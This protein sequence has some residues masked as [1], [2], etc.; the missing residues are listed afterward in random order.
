MTSSFNDDETCMAKLRV[1]K[2]F[3]ELYAEVPNLRRCSSEP[4][5]E[6]ASCSRL[7][8]IPRCVTSTHGETSGAVT[9]SPLND[10]NGTAPLDTGSVELTD[11]LRSGDKTVLFRNIP[12]KIGYER[13]MRELSHVGLDGR[14]D[15]LYLP[16]SVRDR[17]SNRGFCFINFMNTED[18]ELFVKKFTNRFEGVQSQKF[19]RVGRANVQGRKENVACLLASRNRVE[20][21]ADPVGLRVS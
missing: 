1:W 13:I 6:L 5:S 15:F 17:H 2:T 7:S 9:A 3:F 14:Y 18:V 19:A 21:K 10:S 20:F 4:A 8:S 16:K 11:K 12:C